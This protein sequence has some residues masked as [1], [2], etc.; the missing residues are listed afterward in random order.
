MGIG[1]SN[2]VAAAV[3]ALV[4]GA[5]GRVCRRRPAVVH[6]LWLLVL[7]KLVTPP[8][9]AVAVPW[10]AEPPE[11]GDLSG[12][13]VLPEP[14]APAAPPIAEDE[15]PRGVAVLVD[16]VSEPEPPA[17]AA[18]TEPPSWRWDHVLCGLWLAG[19]V[20]WFVLAL[21]RVLRFQHLLR[22]ARPAP[23]ALRQTVAGLAR[24]LGL[25]RCP[26]VLLL[27]G[28]LAPLV[29]AAGGRPRLCLPEGLPA[30]VGGAALETLL[31]HELAH[32]RRRDHWVRRL[33]FLVLGL[34]WWHPVAWY[35]RREL[36]EAEEQCCDA[37][38]VAVLPGAGRTYANALVD[39][40][41]F[42][43]ADGP[44]VP[45]LAS[46]IGQI[47]DLKRRL[48]M[49]V[50]GTTPRGLDRAGV[51]ALLGLGLLVPLWPHWAQADPPEAPPAG[52][53]AA[54]DL[55]RE[56]DELKRLEAELQK[57]L[58]EVREL[59]A[60]LKARAADQ[61]RGNVEAL[62][63]RLILVEKER[64][65]RAAAEVRERPDL[66]R[67]QVG[68]RGTVIRIEIV[69]TDK[70]DEIKD[71][72]RR[73]EKELGGKGRIRVAIEER[74][75][76]NAVSAPR[77]LPGE[78]VRPRFAPPDVPMGPRPPVRDS[79][80]RKLEDLQRELDALRREIRDT[81][82]GGGPPPPPDRGRPVPPPPPPAPG[83]PPGP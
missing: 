62:R 24:R 59:E 63:K 58:A 8:L 42:L 2:A 27:P 77:A 29:W 15:A 21:T 61:A 10:P 54:V 80:E 16:A 53:P 60:R 41:D 66:V 26:E 78:R 31:V 23:P 65:E 48:S 39:I 11:S 73:I 30:T 6:G 76:G 57:K 17:D 51:L 25:R 14:A 12:L 56:Q 44:A 45:V 75:E 69:G 9:V 50:R 70:A 52:V 49:I 5:A 19:S 3:L 1:L 72:L 43:S 47:A 82:P 20:G 38:V 35:A 4:A 13:V 81:R 28:R 37:W 46:G 33:E 7:V 36:R 71:I 64:A 22:H 34:Y 32:V 67:A 74:R 83:A 79:L 55:E 68:Q 40:L 18:G